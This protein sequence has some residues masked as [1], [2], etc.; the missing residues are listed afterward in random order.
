MCEMACS[1]Q[2]V[3]NRGKK[4]VYEKIRLVWRVCKMGKRCVRMSRNVLGRVLS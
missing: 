3:S 1:G 4:F 2:R